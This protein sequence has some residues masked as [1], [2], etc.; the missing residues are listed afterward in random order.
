MTPLRRIDDKAGSC[1]G[2]YSLNSVEHKGHRVYY[3]RKEHWDNVNYATAEYII[4]YGMI[5]N[6]SKTPAW[7]KRDL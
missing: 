2:C 4:H 7:C 5:G 3:C 1:E 6:P